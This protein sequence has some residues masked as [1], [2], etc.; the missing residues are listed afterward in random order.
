[1]KPKYHIIISVVALAF[2]IMMAYAKNTEITKSIRW[3]ERLLTWDDFPIIDNIP[4]DYHA[5]VYSVIQ[6]EGK[7]EEQY[8]HIYAQMIPSKSGRV[9]DEDLEMEQLLI[10]EQLHFNIT[11]YHARL[12]RKEAI[13]IGKEKLTNEDLQRLGK[14]YLEGIDSMQDRYD[15]ESKHNTEMHKQRYWE[16]YVA[17]LLR[18]TAYYANQDLYSYQEFLKETTQW[19]R[20]VYSTLE[21][22]LLTSFPEKAENKKYGE[23]YHVNR[24]RDSIIIKYYINGKPTNGGFFEA[25]QCI[26]TFPNTTTREVQLFDPKGK[27]FSNITEA[28]ITRTITDGKGNIVR[29]YYD[30]NGQQV[31]TNGIFTKTGIWDAAKKSMYSSYFDKDGNTV[32]YN[33]AFHELRI[34]GSNKVTK[35]IS[36]FNKAGN[37]MRDKYLASIYE[38]E[39]DENFK[40]K[41]VK[42][43]YEDGKYALGIDGYHTVFEHDEHGNTKSEAFLD[44]FG[45]NK[46]DADGIH[47]YVYTFDIYDNCT[48]LRKYNIRELPTKGINDLYH[49]VYVYDTL[50]R[51]T[52]S[53]DYYPDYILKFSENKDGAF[54]NEYL[55][56]DIVNLKSVDAYGNDAVNDSGI[57]LTKQFLTDKKEVIREEFFGPEGAWAKTE[58][59]VV[60]YNYKLDERGNQIE[61]AAFD[62]LGKPKAWQ[63]DVSI[64]RWEFDKNNNKTKTTYFTM[65]NK[66]ANALQ[67]VTYNVF[68]YDG[69]NNIVERTNYDRNMNPCLLDGVFRTN[70]ITNRF[71]KD[72]IATNYDV[73]NK[74]VVGNGIIK[75]K[76]NPQGIL[77]SESLYNEY[78]QPVLN[79]FGI[80][81]TVYDH[82][83][84]DRYLG[85]TYYGKNG[86]RIN[87]T[88][89]TSSIEFKLNPSGFVLSYTYY[90]KNQKRVL[91]PEGFHSL[92]NFY[93][94]MDEVVRT[95][96]YG[97]D[98]K[99]M[100][101]AMGIADYVYQIDKSGRTVRISFF[102]A[103]NNLT[104]DADGVAEYF[105]LPYLNGLF[106]LEKQLNAKGEEVTAAAI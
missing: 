45:K 99:L 57:L 7:R 12:F 61:V 104:E 92:E 86:E 54:T 66:L 91:G 88:D 53:A 2:L 17:G 1:M 55:G 98:Q 97:T 56:D 15:K 24:K 36:Y 79:E 78:N 60:A 11:E 9:L 3:S 83:K 42:K 46:A 81:I 63:E 96:T 103:E 21:G 70:I 44:Q 52:F 26:I 6:F 105:Y 32:K 29:T 22:E 71:G 72:S 23:V 75:Y 27:P 30:R 41:T 35:K 43:F 49:Q 67:N 101:N 50:G 106:Y 84:F 87:S 82:D 13:G 16:L 77:L 5:Q 62:S 31:S 37:P 69:N 40:I 58:D 28:H 34:M 90:D 39:T 65:D 89:G 76:Y 100:N 73:N 51:I 48:D 85:Y 8:L 19:Y 4:G 95:S 18:E 25:A 68:K 20:S 64:T 14:K 47:K 38:Y 93:N 80:H 10:H 102:D 74:I 33:D 59:G 94:D